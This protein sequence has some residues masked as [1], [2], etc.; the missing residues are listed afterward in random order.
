MSCE[1]KRRLSGGRS[2]R[3]SESH[4]YP[5]S[6]NF[7]RFTDAMTRGD[8]PAALRAFCGMHGAIPL[9]SS[10]KGFTQLTRP[11]SRKGGEAKIHCVHWVFNPVRFLF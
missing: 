6:G 11:I 4:R 5:D 2:R 3:D 10:L 8:L 7:G 1:S 9:R